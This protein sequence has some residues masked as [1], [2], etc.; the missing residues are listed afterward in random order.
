MLRCLH[1]SAQ[2]WFSGSSIMYVL[3]EE[4][5]LPVIFLTGCLVWA[6]IFP[7]PANGTIVARGF[8]MSTDEFVDSGLAQS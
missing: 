7:S 3:Y 2:S 8:V 1:A 5:W 6:V 4:A